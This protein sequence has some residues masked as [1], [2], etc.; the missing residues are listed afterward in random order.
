MFKCGLQLKAANNRINTV[1]EPRRPLLL[2]MKS[3]SGFGFSQIFDSSSA[4]SPK[5]KRG[6]LPKSAPDPW[7]PLV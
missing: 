6:V 4:P 1:H 3:D 2:K 5:E 7:P